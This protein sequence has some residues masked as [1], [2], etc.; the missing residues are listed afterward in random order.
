MLEQIFRVAIPRHSKAMVAESNL[1]KIVP[2]ELRADLVVVLF[3][4]KRPVFAIVVEVQRQ[5]DEDKARAWPLYVTELSVRHGCPVA[6]LVVTASATVA[7]WASRPVFLGPSLTCHPFVL[8]PEE[9][10]QI[11]SE[12]E[13]S[14][15]PHLSFLSVLAHGRS[16]PDAKQIAVAAVGALRG[17]DDK[18]GAVYYD[19]IL[20]SV[21]RGLQK[22]L[23]AM[24][25]SGKYDFLSDYAKQYVAKGRAEGKAQGK[26]EGKAEML[27][28]F[29]RHRRFAITA[30]VEAKV[31]AAPARDLERWLFRAANA[32]TLDE[33]F[34]TRGKAK[35]TGSRRH[36][37]KKSRRTRA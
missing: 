25:Q 26:A 16:A 11:R 13:A 34:Q 31:R 32:K 5:E 27:L 6:L 4:G 14:R 21:R 9:I 36:T 7:A 1:T 30:S 33:V 12:V 28:A 18:T 20:R 22:E 29:L 17:L 24:V 10:P 37:K 2:T 35:A 19:W 8:G 15:A 3:S 23:I